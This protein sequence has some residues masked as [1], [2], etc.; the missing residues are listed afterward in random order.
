MAER[1]ILTRGDTYYP[2]CLE[3][4]HSPPRVLYGIGDP[5]LLSTPMLS[6]IGAR[7]ATPYGIAIAE[8]TARVAVDYGVTVVSGG[9]MGCD[10]AAGMSA[11]SAG[12][13][14][15]VVLGCGADVIYP[16][17]S[18]P[19]IL[20]AQEQGVVLSLDPWKTPPRR[21]AFPRRNA[22]IAALGSVLVVT[23]AGIRS[24]TM[25]TA[26]AAIDLG[27]TLYAIPGSIFSSTSAGTNRLIS[28]GA[29]IISDESSLAVSLALD[30]GTVAR[31]QKDQTSPK[32]R[33]ISALLAS[34][35]RPEE[36]AMRLGE[37]VLTLMRTLTD[38]EASGIIQRLSDGRYTPT[39]EYHLGLVDKPKMRT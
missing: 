2:K 19:L 35:S 26:E 17:S 5:T 1:W 29:R 21:F 20:T 25:T 16:R 22:I 28:E 12:G 15:I 14:T 39:R 37:D 6:V 34:P 13:K 33:I 10:F 27:R 18:E 38:F 9:A 11:L 30:F 8:M 3:D 24:G 31:A 36:L 4:L 23:E 7:R 32:S